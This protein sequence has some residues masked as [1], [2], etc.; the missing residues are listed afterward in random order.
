MKDGS[1]IRR[2]SGENLIQA[3]GWLG[4]EQ[5]R[6]APRVLLGFRDPDP[7]ISESVHKFYQAEA[8]QSARIVEDY[9]DSEINADLTEEVDGYSME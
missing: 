8:L 6:T 7:G 1:A 3:P 2:Y 4:W 5:Q 9:T